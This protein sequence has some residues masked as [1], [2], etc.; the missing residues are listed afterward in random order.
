MT[1]FFPRRDRTDL[2]SE[3]IRVRAAGDRL[4]GALWLLTLGGLVVTMV[5]VYQL[6]VLHGMPSGTAMIVDPILSGAMFVVLIGDGVLARNGWKS[7]GS[8]QVLK[9]GSGTLTL[10]LNVW[11]AVVNRDLAAIVMHAAIPAVVIVLADVI[12]AYRMRFVELADNHEERAVAA[13]RQAIEDAARKAREEAEEAARHARTLAEEEA[14]RK[15]AER[16][17]K[18]AAKDITRD[19]GMD[20]PRVPATAKPQVK[21]RAA[22]DI[23]QD[24]TDAERDILM[25][26]LGQGEVTRTDIIKDSRRVESTVKAALRTLGQ[27]GY[28]VTERRGIY[29]TVTPGIEGQSMPEQADMA[30][31]TGER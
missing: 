15:A 22:M 2:R 28:V 5:N 18:V 30:T 26:M 24:L 11:Q 29:R 10:T 23:P 27:K 6:C 19:I 1:K 17:A 14:A 25:V 31:G 9:Y 20:K 21:G 13:E 12:P 7:T 3:A 8:A 16:A 4:A